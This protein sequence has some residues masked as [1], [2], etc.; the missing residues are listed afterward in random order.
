MNRSF[1]RL[2]VA[3]LLILFAVD[4]S[5]RFLPPERFTF[6]AWD[7]M[8]LGRGRLGIF[9]P[10][11]TYF[12]PRASGDLAH[13]GNFPD[14]RQF[15]AESFT[16]DG[17]GNRNK[18]D[19]FE[20]RPA[21]LMLL[22]TSFAVGSGVDD[23]HNL[24]SQIQQLSG[25]KVYNG[26]GPSVDQS[27]WVLAL[28]RKL[29]MDQTGHGTI[30]LEYLERL[31]VR[32]SLIPDQSDWLGDSLCN[33]KPLWATR[34]GWSTIFKNFLTLSPLEIYSRNLL[35]RLQ[36]DVILPNPYK[37]GVVRETL[38]DGTPILFLPAEVESAYE[39]RDE[40]GPIKYWAQLSDK[41]KE[42][43]LKFVVLLVPNKYT[44]YYS[45]LHEPARGEPQNRHYLSDLESRLRQE[46][47]PVVNLTD[48]YMQAATSEFKRGRYLYWL[49]DT[50]WS[51][52]GIE[53]AAKAILKETNGS[54]PH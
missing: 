40:D 1:G 12:N 42:A 24:S 23:E 7:A 29:K 47:I 4:F 51:A 16:T 21:D 18:P 11:R 32:K 37:V 14:L 6:R 53:I 17:C 52:T 19:I 2:V 27:G 54:N 22:G 15:R 38:L 50:H 46:G 49:D 33:P 31:S 13:L 26:A 36:N 41:L 45:L 44:I 28:A 8:I 25:L 10:N 43:H 5:L 39:F 3:L 9:S 48:V 30:I 34:S 35:Q 20:G